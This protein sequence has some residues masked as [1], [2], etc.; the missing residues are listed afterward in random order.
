MAITFNMTASGSTWTLNLNLVLTQD[1]IRGWCWKYSFQYEF[2]KGLE[3]FTTV[4]LKL[5]QSNDSQNDVKACLK[6]QNNRKK[7]SQ[8]TTTEWHSLFQEVSTER[9]KRRWASDNGKQVLIIWKTLVLLIIL[10]S[11]L[12]Q[13]NETPNLR[14]D[15]NGTGV[16]PLQGTKIVI[17]NLQTSVT[18]VNKEIIASLITS[19]SFIGR[20]P[21]ALWRHWSFE[22]RQVGQSRACG[23]H[24]HQQ[25]RCRQV[26]NELKIHLYLNLFQGS[27]DLPQQATGWKTNEV[28]H[29]WRQ[30]VGCSSLI[31]QFFLA[32]CSI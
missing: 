10:S 30:Q 28:H 7:K 16:S 4:C 25:G 11:S 8:L 18:Q 2:L 20:H 26:G 24:L 32:T 15:G 1:K 12:L 19:S 6:I 21:W 27:G 9:G 14:L 31:A 22:T 13:L 5:D 23:S 29:G 3:P 17:Q